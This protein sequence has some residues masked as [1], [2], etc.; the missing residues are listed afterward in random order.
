LQPLA[1]EVLPFAQKSMSPAQQAVFEFVCGPRVSCALSLWRL[2]VAMLTRPT[3][4]TRTALSSR[5][6]TGI[7]EGPSSPRVSECRSLRPV[8]TAS[9]RQES[10]LRQPLERSRTA[11][12]KANGR[13]TSRARTT[14]CPHVSQAEQVSRPSR[15]LLGSNSS[16]KIGDDGMFCANPAPVLPFMPC[17][18]CTIESSAVRTTAVGRRSKHGPPLRETS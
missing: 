15:A 3:A 11:T 9:L 17:R 18:M 16:V 2:S 14:C 8:S 7:R 4:C 6:R 12:P 10:G 5:S 13:S 1:D